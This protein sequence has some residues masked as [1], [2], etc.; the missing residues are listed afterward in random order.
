MPDAATLAPF[1]AEQKPEPLPPEGL[2]LHMAVG[3]MLNSPP[4]RS[5]GAEPG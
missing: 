4:E 2:R 5:N 1:L 3:F